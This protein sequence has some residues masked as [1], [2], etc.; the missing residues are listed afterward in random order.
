M[1]GSDVP[2]T[3]YHS[4]RYLGNQHCATREELSIRVILRLS[5]KFV[6]TKNIFHERIFHEMLF[7]KIQEKHDEDKE[8]KPRLLIISVGSI[9]R[10]H[11]IDI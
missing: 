6:S 10:K 11:L 4:D 7:H 5:T 9:E 2:G 3:P 1:E 8:S